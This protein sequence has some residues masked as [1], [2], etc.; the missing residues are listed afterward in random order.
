MTAGV[1][2]NGNDQFLQVTIDLRQFEKQMREA[3]SVVYFRLRDF[4]GATFGKHRQ[5]WL[6]QKGTRFGRGGAGGRG[7]RVFKI[8]EGP[9]SVAD[10]EVAYHIRPTEQRLPDP[11]SARRGLSQLVAEAFTGNQILPV[12]EFGRDIRSSRFMAVP[13]KTRPKTPKAWLAANPDKRLVW[14]PSKTN[15]GTLVVYEVQRKRGRGRPRKGEPPR[16]QERLRLRFI[17]TRFV[18][19]KPTLRM[20]ETWDQLASYRGDRFRFA[21]DAIVRDIEGGQALARDQVSQGAG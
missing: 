9:T 18:D 16:V 15:P 14:R 17:W 19:M 3:P 5:Q 21:A 4:L 12:H 8:N 7:I 2:S 6:R 20:Y 11:A 10:N 1:L 13:V